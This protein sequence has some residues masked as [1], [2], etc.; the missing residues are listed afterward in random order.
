MKVASVKF[1]GFLHFAIVMFVIFGC[2]A[3]NQKV[4]LVHVIFLPILVLHWKTNQGVCYLTEL[5]IKIQGKRS[6]ELPGK[7][8]MQGG[9]TES[10][11]KKLFGRQ[12][13]RALLQNLTYSI[14]AVS[15]M[16]SILKYLN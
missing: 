16:I 6:G 3:T 14:M 11:F 10:L 5:E 8:E 13:S 1:L 4:L 9:F 7:T 12:P 2:L 15:W